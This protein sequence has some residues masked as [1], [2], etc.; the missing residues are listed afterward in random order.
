MFAKLRSHLSFANVIAMVALFVALSGTS[1]AVAKIGA[2][3]IRKNAV[4]AK[5]I[6]KSQ[7]RSKQIKNQS[8]RASD[9]APGVIGTTLA[10]QRRPGQ[11]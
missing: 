10:V 8:V 9:L 7:V 3:D 6:K 2:K 1:Y 11:A 4:R 5:H